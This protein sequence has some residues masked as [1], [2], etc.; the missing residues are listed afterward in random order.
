MIRHT[1]K[2]LA[3]A[4]LAEMT[5]RP[6]FRQTFLH[7]VLTVFMGLPLR[8]EYVRDLMFQDDA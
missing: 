7:A 8:A 1:I 6:R 2:V 5:E 4:A 3:K